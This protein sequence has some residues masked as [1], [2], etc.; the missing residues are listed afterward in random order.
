MQDYEAIDLGFSRS[1][2]T[3]FSLVIFTLEYVKSNSIFK[4]L[5]FYH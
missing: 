4:I 5:V 1:A 3:F 2:S